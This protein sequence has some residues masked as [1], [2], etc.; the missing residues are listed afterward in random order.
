MNQFFCLK[1]IETGEV[2][3]L[4]QD[5][6]SLGRVDTCTIAIESS[7]L[8]R[9]HAN[10]RV[11]HDHIVVQDLASKNGT[12]VNQQRIFQPTNAYAGDLIAFGLETYQLTQTEPQFPK[13]ETAGDLLPYNDNTSNATMI[14]SSFMSTSDLEKNLESEITP[15]DMDEQLIEQAL[16]QKIIDIN[17]TPAIFVFKSG[18]RRGLVLELK[19]PRGSVQSWAIGRSQLADVVLDDPTVSSVHAYIEL[20]RNRWMLFDNHSTNGIKLNN[21]HVK[22]SPCHSGDVLSLGNTELLFHILKTN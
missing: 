13:I 22:Q 2:Y 14:R 17:K 16:S 1:H 19:L 9:Q 5:D 20:N 11:C 4:D 21:V 3:K 7:A 12:Y 15:A 10:I 18:R 6:I 8:S